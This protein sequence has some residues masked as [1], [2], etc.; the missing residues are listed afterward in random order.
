MIKRGRRISRVKTISS[1]QKEE[2]ESRKIKRFFFILFDIV[3]LISFVLAL[4][5]TYL[6][7]YTKTI[8][9]LIIGGLLLLY[10]I[11]REALRKKK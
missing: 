3:I 9:F 11:V 1:K 5:F 8:L 2:Y 10:F 6:Q 7:D 4:F